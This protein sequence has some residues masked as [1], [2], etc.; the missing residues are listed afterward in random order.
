M[1]LTRVITGVLLAVALFYCLS[2]A[3]HPAAPI[4]LFVAFAGVAGVEYCALRWRSL[5]GP[6][7]RFVQRPEISREHMTVGALYAATVPIAAAGNSWIP[8]GEVGLALVFVWMVV[9]GS[10][11]S[12]WF[13]MTEKR[14]HLATSKLINAMAGFVYIGIPAIA[15]YRMSIIT[16]PNAPK[17]I[18]VYFALSVV[19]MGDIMAYFGGRLFGHHKLLPR[20][21]PKKTIEGSAFGLLASG[22]TGVGIAWHYQFSAPLWLVFIVCL[23]AGFAGQ[24]GDLVASALKRVANC[25]DSSGLL[26]GHGGALDRIDAVLI[27][28][29]ICSLIFIV[30]EF[31]LF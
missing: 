15:L 28:S 25:K 2:F 13:Y 23:G 29:P 10:C 19:L 31:G 3:H 22:L 20:V 27:G 1:L 24:I 18:A 17:G 16:L 4:L 21:S 30:E 6:G 14:M 8:Q 12:A 5:E 9:C 11:L 26:P 7:D